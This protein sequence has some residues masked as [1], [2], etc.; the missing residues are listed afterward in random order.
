MD[1]RSVWFRETGEGRLK[2]QLLIETMFCVYYLSKGSAVLTTR[3]P[4]IPPPFGILSPTLVGACSVSRAS[5]GGDPPLA[6]IAVTV[7]STSVPHAREQNCRPAFLRFEAR[8]YYGLSD[9]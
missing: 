7:H 4:K 9:L 6:G 2:E 3:A 8:T 1:A 5:F